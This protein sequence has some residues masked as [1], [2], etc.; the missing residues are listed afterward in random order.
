MISGVGIVLEKKLHS[1]GIYYYKQ[2]AKWGEKEMAWIDAY[3]SFKGRVAR[4]GW[5][6][7]AQELAKKSDN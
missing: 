6:P 3:L 2:I 7:Q 5:I 1:L 4:E